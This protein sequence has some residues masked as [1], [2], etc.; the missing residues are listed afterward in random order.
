MTYED[1]TLLLGNLPRFTIAAV[2]REPGGTRTGTLQAIIT[3]TT[4]AGGR[5]H[6]SP[7]GHATTQLHYATERGSASCPFSTRKR[8][9]CCR[10]PG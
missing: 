6:C 2:T 3:L 9:S 5:R 8:G 1:L 7:R 10:S 4:V